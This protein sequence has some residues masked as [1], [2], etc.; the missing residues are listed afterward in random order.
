MVLIA[1]C[2]IGGM[3]YVTAA[4]IARHAAAADQAPKLSRAEGAYFVCRQ[5]VRARLRD[6]SGLRWSEFSASTSTQQGAVWSV[7]VLYASGTAAPTFA[8]CK[9]EEL[10]NG[11][12]RDISHVP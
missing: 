8:F 4:G 11:D 1:V 10:S 2:A 7:R 5:L 3:L 6:P 9:L 12:F